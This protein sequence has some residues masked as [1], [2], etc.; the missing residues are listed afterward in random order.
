MNPDPSITP[1]C[2]ICL[3]PSGLDIC[4]F[5]LL[6]LNCKFI[7]LS[8]GLSH[9]IELMVWAIFWPLVTCLKGVRTNV[10][11]YTLVETQ[12]LE[13]WWRICLLA[14]CHPWLQE[15]SRTALFLLSYFF[16]FNNWSVDT[17][18]AEKLQHRMER[19]Q[20]LNVIRKMIR[21]EE[22]LGR[23]TV[24]IKLGIWTVIRFRSITGTSI[25]LL[26]AGSGKKAQRIPYRQTCMSFAKKPSACLLSG[27]AI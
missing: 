18:A 10:W 2:I 13:L 3:D 11:D 21:C 7:K 20:W 6:S 26:M 14:A 8:L 5:W 4:I 19:G 15:T 16:F 1:A 24:N 12:F 9:F 23:Q 27:T 17:Q 25:W 22:V